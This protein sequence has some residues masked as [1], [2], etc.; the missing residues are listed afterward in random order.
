MKLLSPLV[1]QL[2][3]V[4]ESSSVVAK[5]HGYGLV[6]VFFVL[7]GFLTGSHVFGKSIKCFGNVDIPDVNDW[8]LTQSLYTLYE[9][10]RYV[11][12]ILYFTIIL[13]SN[14]SI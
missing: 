5:L 7:G 4:D 12:L 13:S 3:S 9:A 8:C 10:A 2:K 14:Q 6:S 1:S 11:L